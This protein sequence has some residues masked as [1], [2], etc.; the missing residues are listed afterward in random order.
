M[1]QCQPVHL[2]YP[3]IHFRIIRA[4]NPLS[5]LYINRKFQKYVSVSIFH[6]HRTSFM[7]SLFVLYKERW[8]VSFRGTYWLSSAYFILL[9]VC[10][11]FLYLS[12]FI[13]FCRA[14]YLLMYRGKLVNS[15]N[16]AVELFLGSW[17]KFQV[18]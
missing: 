8:M 16:K 5:K 2:A 12:F 11:F 7:R 1:V 6:C 10:R 13:F 3:K 17:V 14:Y 4:V 15:S 9:C 18:T